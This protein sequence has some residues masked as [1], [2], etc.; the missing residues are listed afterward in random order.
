[1]RQNR[2][3]GRSKAIILISSVLLAVLIVMIVLNRNLMPALKS[4]SESRVHA[5]A[6]NA[7]N[8]AILECM[9]NSEQYTELTKAHL[10]G[11]KLYLLQ[12]DTRGMNMFAAECTERALEKIANI[13]EQGISI[14]VGTVSG[15]SMLS[16]W[17]PKINVTF[18][19]VGS[20]TSEFRS[21]F[22]STGI[23]QTLYRVYIRLTS[24]VSIVLPGLNATSTVLYEAAIIESVIIGDVP[25]VYTDVANEEDMLNLIPTELP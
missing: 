5:A 11:E 22:T 19:P 16:G 21:E 9:E 6:A 25:Q 7:M 2:R 4:Y 20:V 15:I 12:A 17:G 10:N 1:M 13:G 14:P 3:T 18:S 24:T 23:N 8:Q